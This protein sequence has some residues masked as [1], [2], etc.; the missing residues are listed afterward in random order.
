[1]ATPK[2][3]NLDSSEEQAKRKQE[4]HDQSTEDFASFAQGVKV[5]CLSDEEELLHHVPRIYYK[6]HAG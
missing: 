3:E 5:G 2:W 1:M 6:L 4:I